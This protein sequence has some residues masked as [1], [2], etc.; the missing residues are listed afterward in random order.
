MGKPATLCKGFAVYTLVRLSLWCKNLVSPLEDTS[1]PL[2]CVKFLKW[3]K[4]TGTCQEHSPEK[5]VTVQNTLS[6]KRPAQV[7]T[8]Q[9]FR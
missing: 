7:I 9:G 1:C 6:L 5:L 8:D 2:H 4:T 3:L